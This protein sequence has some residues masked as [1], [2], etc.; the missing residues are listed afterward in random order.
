MPSTAAR[1]LSGTKP[2][3][4]HQCHW[5]NDTTSSA[6]LQ[7]LQKPCKQGNHK[8]QQGCCA[9]HVHTAPE[10]SPVMPGRSAGTEQGTAG[11][12]RRFRGTAMPASSTGA[13]STGTSSTG[14]FRTAKGH[15]NSSFHGTSYEVFDIHRPFPFSAI[16]SLNFCGLRNQTDHFTP[17]VTIFICNSCV[18]LL[19]F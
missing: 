3:R 12:R 8:G 2:V 5:G 18:R 14:R 6:D 16:K 4:A 1:S 7:G 19:A 11:R 15:S 13:S 17:K 10:A 9:Y